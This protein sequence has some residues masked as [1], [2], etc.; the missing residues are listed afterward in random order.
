MLFIL[1]SHE[2]HPHGDIITD[3]VFSWWKKTVENTPENINIITLT[4]QPLGGTT[5]GT[6]YDPLTFLAFAFESFQKIVAA[7]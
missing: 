5:R 1:M 3:E 4:H 6:K 2:G 7:F